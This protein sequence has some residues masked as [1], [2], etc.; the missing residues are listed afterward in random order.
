[1]VNLPQQ[2]V[3]TSPFF[4]RQAAVL[5]VQIEALGPLQRQDV[6]GILSELAVWV[7]WITYQ[8][9]EIMMYRYSLSFKYNI[10]LN[11]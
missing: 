6:Q 5:H 3:G 11:K 7:G 9:L 8:K 4:P 1:M 10:Y 2:L